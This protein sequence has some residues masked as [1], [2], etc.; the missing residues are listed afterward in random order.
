MRFL[1]L[2]LVLAAAACSG[3]AATHTA[4]AAGSCDN[5]GFVR[6]QSG[7]A[8]GSLQGDRLVDVC[9]SVS[10]VRTARRTRS[11]RHGYFYVQIPGSGAIEVVANLD[12]MAR[13]PSGTPPAWPWVAVGDRVVVRGRYYYDNPQ[14]QGI[15]W[16]EDDTGRNWPHTGYV[17]VCEPGGGS[18]R[19]YQ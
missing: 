9:G 8:D 5:A 4:D 15:D 18:C 7:F 13:A 6:V 17:I 11:G 3:G 16:T 1:A 2:A 10:R 12:A 19:T 14:S